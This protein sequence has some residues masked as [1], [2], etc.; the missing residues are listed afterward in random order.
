MPT[1]Q[2]KEYG[3][4]DDEGASFRSRNPVSGESR[5]L[6]LA[7]EAQIVSK[8]LSNL[9]NTIVRGGKHSI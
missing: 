4:G 7:Q 5:P 3:K 6:L 2:L 9:W 1:K 8:P